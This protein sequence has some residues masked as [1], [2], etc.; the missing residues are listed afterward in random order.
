MTASQG[1]RPVIGNNVSDTLSSSIAVGASSI[2]VN[3]ISRWGTGIG[4][5]IV[6][7]GTA[8]EEI[9]LG[10]G[11]SG[12]SITVDTNATTYKEGTTQV[13]HDAGATIESVP[14]AGDVND[15]Y[16]AWV[17]AHD[18]T[19]AHKSGLTLTSPVINTGVTGTALASAAEITTGTEPA[20]LVTPKE[21]KD[22]GITAAGSFPR[23]FT[24]YLDGT[25]VVA[26]E[27]GAKYIV[28]ANMTVVSIKTKTV[29]GTATVR[30]QKNTTDVDASI[31]VTSSVATETTITSAA[32]TADE[33]LTLDITAVSSCVGLTVIVN[34]TQ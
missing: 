12:S 34:C 31:S 15:A 4:K 29:S 5:V 21:L 20:K 17:V 22:A 3:T 33:V 23:A 2:P 26:D 1:F 28:P 8:N 11:I 27:V 16:T 9:Y 24:W 7:R 19:G 13:G 6:D 14:T 10:T 30:V 32:L 25:S 18:A